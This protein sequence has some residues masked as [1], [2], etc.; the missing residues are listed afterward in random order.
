MVVVKIA[1]FGLARDIYEKE[2]YKVEDKRR[3]LPVKWMA[4]ECLE[5][6]RFSIK[7]DVVSLKTNFLSFSMLYSLPKLK[8]LH[9]DSYLKSE[10]P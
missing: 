8:T 7:S 2:Y 6:Y 4:L 5:S 9:T 3:P 1:D 10:I